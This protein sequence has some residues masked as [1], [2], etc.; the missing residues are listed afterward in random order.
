MKKFKEIKQ[1]AIV[2]SSITCDK[3]GK[4]YDVDDVLE[5]Q[6]FLHINFVGGYGSVFGDGYRIECDICQYCLKEMIKDLYK[7]NY[8]S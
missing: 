2:L 8:I 3:C 7:R 1:P 5:L 6:E 4:E